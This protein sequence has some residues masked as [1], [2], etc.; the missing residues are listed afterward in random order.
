VGGWNAQ[1]TQFDQPEAEFHHSLEEP[2]KSWLIWQFDA[3]GGR[4]LTWADLAVVEL[5]AQE[6]ADSTF[7]GDLVHL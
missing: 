5:R 7:E 2:P 6:V 4:V 1:H 3:K